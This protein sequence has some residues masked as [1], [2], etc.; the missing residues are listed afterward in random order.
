MHVGEKPYVVTAGGHAELAANALT[1]AAM[2]GMLDQLLPA[3]SR[4]ALNELGAVEY[5]L[6][7]DP[8]SPGIRYSVVAARGGNDIWIEVRRRKAAEEPVHAVRH[9]EVA[10]AVE[11]PPAPAVHVAPLP[12]ERFED[13]PTPIALV[14]PAELEQLDEPFHR[15]AAPSLDAHEEPAPAFE[16]KSPTDE[17]FFAS[18]PIEETLDERASSFDELPPPLDFSEAAL[19]LNEVE[20][21]GLSEVEGPAPGEIEEPNDV[22][23]R[24]S[25]P[26]ARVNV[27]VETST[28]AA[29]PPEARP[30]LETPVR[31]HAD[32]LHHLLYVAAAHGASA[33]YVSP[34]AKSS[35]RVDGEIRVLDEQPL[36]QEQLETGLRA[37]LRATESETL[38]M[39]EVQTREVADVGRVQYLGFRDHRGIGAIFRMLPGRAISAEQ[40]GLS[41]AIQAL[42]TEPE[43]LLL[44]AGARSAGKSTLVSGLVDQIN[45]TRR[46]HLIIVENEIQYVHVNRTSFISQR[47]A[48]EEERFAEA[49]RTAIREAPDVL[50]ID[51]AM[52]ADIARMALEAAA[53]GPLVIASIAAPTTSTALERFTAL[54]GDYPDGRALFAE[55]LRGIITQALLRKTGGGRAAAREVLVNVPSVASLVAN[56]QFDQIPP[57][58][59]SG[60]RVGMV[61]VNDALL[62]L[63]QSGAL[64]VR[65]AYRK[66]PDQRELLEMLQRAGFDTTFAEKLA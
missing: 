65:Q 11:E 22:E 4:K 33:L 32:P 48:R 7:A 31:K 18:D 15:A 60:R 55:H 49:F 50:V 26:L 53:D 10:V 9:R 64:D 46:D 23:E 28:P 13:Q 61:P 16:L 27:R 54:L 38:P 58:L 20:G 45:R 37:L 6:P 21:L 2:T 59:N 8:A 24:I 41:A 34:E 43:G 3:D 40:A 52:N 5:H 35:L 44:V 57:V 62:G 63:V 39:G 19:A 30:T 12:P 29:A 1:V 66:S 42:C 56:G 51:G 25:V 36:T 47:E 17:D 14:Q